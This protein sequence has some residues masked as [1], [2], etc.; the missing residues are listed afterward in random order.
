[1]R[2]QINFQQKLLVHMAAVIN[3]ACKLQKFVLC[4][5]VYTQNI[6]RWL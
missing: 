5:E 4:Y 3:A 2:L 1:M 6:D